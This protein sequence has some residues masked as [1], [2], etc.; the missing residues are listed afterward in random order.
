M[1]GLQTNLNANAIALLRRAQGLIDEPNRW[2]AGVMARDEFGE[3]VSPRCVEARCFCIIGALEAV[4]STCRLSL[5]SELM[6]DL[7]DGFGFVTCFNDDGRT[8]HAD[9]VALFDRT[10]ARLESGR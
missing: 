1:S 7:P 6:A 8:T 10:V 5:E 9:V 2:T 4:A 3:V